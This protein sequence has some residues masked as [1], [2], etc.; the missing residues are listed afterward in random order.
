VKKLI[1]D[2]WVTQVIAD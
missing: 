2:W 1:V